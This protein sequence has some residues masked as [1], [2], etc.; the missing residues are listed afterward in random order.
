MP[1]EALPVRSDQCEALGEVL[2][3]AFANDPGTSYSF[4]DPDRRRHCLQWMFSRWI[5][6]MSRR[7]A[8]YTT[9]DLAG[10]AL[11]APPDAEASVPT[12]ELLRGGFLAGFLVMTPGE[13]FR[14]LKVY[15]DATART[16]RHLNTPHW[17][18]DTLGVDP[19]RQGKGVAGALVN[20][21]LRQA[22]SSHTPSY[23]ITH[24]PANVDFYRTFGFEVVEASPL[25]GTSI[26]VTSLRREAK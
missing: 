17:V 11:W 22:D 24:N 14:G 15:R 7:G 9:S 19:P 21:A 26:T 13:Q 8:A 1:P 2:A 4:P 16:H 6:I 18:L 10:V 20:A 5:R 23:V 3:R 25:R 12:L